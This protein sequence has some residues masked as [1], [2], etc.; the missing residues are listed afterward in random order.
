MEPISPKKSILFVDDEA[1]LLEG[2]ARSLR[3]KRHEWEL[4]LAPSV[5]MAWMILNAAD[6]DAIIS[7]VN[8]PGTDGFEFLAQ[9]RDNEKT[10][11]IPF[12]IL[13]GSDDRKIKRAALDAGATD[14]LIKPFDPEELVARINNML[15]IKE[16]QDQIKSQNAQLEQRVKERTSELERSRIELIWRLGKAGEHRD[17]DTGN[18]VM[19]V[20]YYAV[21]L[22]G[23]LGLA[24]SLKERI[25]LTSPLHDLGKIG[26]PD[27]IL[28][29]PAK[30]TP[31]EW[32]VMRT[33]TTI[34][35]EILRG[36]AEFPQLRGLS[37]V[38]TLGSKAPFAE[39]LLA[40]TGARIARS[41]HERWDGKGYP[42]GLA[43]EDIPIEARI[44]SLADVYDALSSKRPYKKA[45]TE[46]EVMSIMR[47]GSGTQF[48]PEVYSVFEKSIDAMRDIGA[49]LVDVVPEGVEEEQDLQSN[50]RR[51]EGA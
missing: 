23:A 22:A 39:S 42:D 38:D 31:E 5:D 36:N 27:S 3:H 18:H 35:A 32:V 6:C 28:L 20:G 41:H 12:V 13:T 49:Q 2:L 46:E 14:L 44:A 7:D 30:L 1:S 16:Y 37:E 4:A 9:V 10:A 29:K 21:E 33:H 25:F 51:R 47:D 43:G 40:V 15:R 8:M 34:G 48:D 50:L 26:I 11:D 45:F 24:D 17:S 19:R